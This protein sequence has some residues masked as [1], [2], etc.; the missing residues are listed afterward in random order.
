MTL[1]LALTR[2]FRQLKNKLEFFWKTHECFSCER[3][4]T[5]RKLLEYYWY[6]KGMI[7]IKAQYR[8]RCWRC[9]VWSSITYCRVRPTDH[10]NYEVPKEAE[11]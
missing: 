3:H 11:E 1:W 9:K 5:S 4:L 7:M 6:D 8:V 10:P 2:P